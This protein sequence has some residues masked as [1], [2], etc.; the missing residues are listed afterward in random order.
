MPNID[1][2]SQLDKVHGGAGAGRA[3]ANAV[4]T[5]LSYGGKALEKIGGLAGGAV[6]IKEGWDY[7][8]GNTSGKES[9]PAAPAQAPGAE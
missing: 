7:L 5:G 4:R 6:A 1:I 8:R 9:A 2:T 3:V